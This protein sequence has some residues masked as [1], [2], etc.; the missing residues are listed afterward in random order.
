MPRP[1]IAA[2]TDVWVMT[3]APS[4]TL[5]SREASSP[6]ITTLKR[7]AAASLRI[8]SAIPVM[9]VLAPASAAVAL[10]LVMAP[11]GA[12]T[13]LDGLHPALA[14]M[15]FT[16]LVGGLVRLEARL[17]RLPRSRTQRLPGR[18]LPVVLM[19]GFEQRAG[20]GQR[21]LGGDLPLAARCA[22][23]GGSGGL[24]LSLAGRRLLAGRVA[25]GLLRRRFPECR[26]LGW[27]FPG[28]SLL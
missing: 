7:R 8:R 17:R 19:L 2:G 3:M 25:G 21:L 4:P 15:H 6:S 23:L 18:R 22:L 13:A 26:L 10:A 11:L 20:V 9:V 28:D 12:D 14:R 16:R 5:Y 27:R 1:P 24:H